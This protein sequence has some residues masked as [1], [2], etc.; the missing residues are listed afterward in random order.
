VLVRFATSSVLCVR[1]HCQLTAHVDTRFRSRSGI[2]RR[3]ILGLEKVLKRGRARIPKGSPPLL[4]M[5]WIP[6]GMHRNGLG[7][8][9]PSSILPSSGE[10]SSVISLPLSYRLDGEKEV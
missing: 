2:E 8:Y 10:R 1:L 9:K 5:A 3:S 4:V 7:Q 6:A